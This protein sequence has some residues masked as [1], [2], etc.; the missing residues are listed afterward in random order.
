MLK[1]GTLHVTAYCI[2][3]TKSSAITTYGNR[4]V[5]KPGCNPKEHT[6]VFSKGYQPQYV[7]GE[8]ERG[9]TK[10]PIAVESAEPG[11]Y[12]SATSR[13]R[14]G[15]TY[16]IE[17]N[18]KVRD[19]GMVVPEHRIMLARYYQDERD[20]GFEAEGDDDDEPEKTTNFYY[21]DE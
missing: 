6:I 5:L 18:V 1:L 21:A 13:L 10:S 14:F 20:N 12:M 15:K 2:L 7:P 19:M 17:C 16:T 3:L 11:E 9:M 8:Y 4:G